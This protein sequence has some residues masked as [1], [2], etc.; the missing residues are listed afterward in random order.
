MG[1]NVQGIQ[2]TVTLLLECIVQV[3][4]SNQIRSR[5]C[6]WSEHSPLSEFEAFETWLAISLWKDRSKTMAARYKSAREMPSFFIM[7]FKVV[8][9]TPRRVAAVLTTPLLSR[10]TRRM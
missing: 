3:S 4:A 8:R 6:E 7:A 1:A 2:R 9:G 5:D 10:K